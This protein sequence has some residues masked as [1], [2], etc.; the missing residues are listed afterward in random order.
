[1]T[2]AEAVDVAPT[3]AIATEP[4]ARKLKKL[5][6]LWQFVR[7][8]PAHLAAA[9]VALV[10]AAVGQIAVL[11]GFK[12]VVDHGFGKGASAASVA[13]GASPAG[14]SDGPC[15]PPMTRSR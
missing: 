13:P 15:S 12:L 11:Q 1:M 4:P 14:R 10:I 2:T 8:Y 7:R 3:Q 6:L 5:T 9:L